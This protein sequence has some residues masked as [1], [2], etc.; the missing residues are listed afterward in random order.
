MNNGQNFRGTCGFYPTIKIAGYFK[1]EVWDFI[2]PILDQ[3]EQNKAISRLNSLKHAI[4]SNYFYQ[5]Y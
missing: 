3:Q 2:L 4:V 1:G 5:A